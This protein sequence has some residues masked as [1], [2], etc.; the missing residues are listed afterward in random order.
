MTNGSKGKRRAP[1]GQ[2]VQNFFWGLLML[3][4]AVLV[5][6]GLLG[7]LGTGAR[8]LGGLAGLAR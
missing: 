6:L 7:V 3:P 1:V 5:V 4:V 8:V 2:P